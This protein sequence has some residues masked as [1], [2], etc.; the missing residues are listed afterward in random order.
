[1]SVSPNERYTEVRADAFLHA[2]TEAICAVAHELHHLRLAFEN[3][4][5]EVNG[6]LHIVTWKGE[7]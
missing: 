4:I 6:N 2:T 7:R 1:M 3:C 5:D